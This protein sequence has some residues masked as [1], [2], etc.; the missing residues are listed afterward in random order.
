MPE[1]SDSPQPPEP[2]AVSKLI[3]SSGAKSAGEA[4]T[5]EILHNLRYQHD[6][7][8]LRLHVVQLNSGPSPASINGDGDGNTTSRMVNLEVDNYFS[9]NYQQQQGRSSSPSRSATSSTATLATPSSAPPA[10]NEPPINV[11]RLISGLPPRHSYIH[12]DLQ[13]HLVKHSIP[14]ASL[15]VQREFVLPLSTAEKWTLS[16]F[17]AVFDAMA[18]RE[19]IVVGSGADA[20]AAVAVA[21][22]TPNGDGGTRV[23][24]NAKRPTS[25]PGSHARVP[26]E[27]QDQKRVLL[28]MRAREGGGGDSTVVY[29]IMQEGEV[30]PRQ[31]G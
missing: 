18:G 24:G 23:N 9:P 4:L 6:W 14:E 8:D 19:R 26:Y 27:H 20:A 17:C 1:A 22:A 21:V 13:L 31:N 15:P 16:R 7:S 5:I 12:P 28:G 25:T 3:E 29:Y 30:K 10:N 11:V 2:S